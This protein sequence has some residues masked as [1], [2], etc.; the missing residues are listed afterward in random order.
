MK[1]VCIV[2]YGAIGPSHACALETVKSAK[3]YAVCDINPSKRALC[4]KKYGVVEYKDFDTMLKDDHID[5]V[6]ICT[7][8][9]LHFQMIAKA[10]K[11]GKDVVVEKPVTMTKTEFDALKKLPGS[12]RV[13]VVFQ[14]RLNPCIR[15]LKQLSG[16]S[17][18][19]KPKS[20]RAVLTWCRNSEYYNDDWHGKRATEGGGLLINQAIHT[21]DYF[22][23]L[24][25]K[26]A[27]IQ[28]QMCNFSLQNIIEV[29]D[30]FTAYLRFNNDVTGI[31]FATNAYSENSSPFFEVSFENGIARYTDRKL[32]IN[33]ILVAEDD[34]YNIGKTYWGNGHVALFQ[35]YYDEN[36]YIS[37][38]DTISTMETVFELYEKANLNN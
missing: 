27:D 13:C 8:H 22:C 3:L 28:V 31:F 34:T 19:G 29:E 21:L 15:K 20:A 16:N 1:Q 23:Y 24:F 2:G 10:L 11:A 37:I 5:S 33:D 38:K 9:Y 7:P 26:P 36:K 35:K 4:T 32:W 25:G 14:N 6:H 18:L 17:T 30:T 12:E